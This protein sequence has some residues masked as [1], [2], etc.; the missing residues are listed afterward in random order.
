LSGAGA[1]PETIAVRG[2]LKKDTIATVHLAG[3]DIFERVRFIGLRN[4][5]EGDVLAFN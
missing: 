4:N 1:K 3:G 5:S 2:I